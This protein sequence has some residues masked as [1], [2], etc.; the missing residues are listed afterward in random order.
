MGRWALGDVS[1]EWSLFSKEGVFLG[2]KLNLDS[3]YGNR[4]SDIA[5]TLWK[6][7]AV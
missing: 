5:V 1:V 6:S 2:D 4:C 7:T 3:R